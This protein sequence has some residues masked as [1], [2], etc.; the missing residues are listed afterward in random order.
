MTI[1]QSIAART[2]GV[3]V[4]LLTLGSAVYAA[5]R[6]SVP[7][8]VIQ[9]AQAPDNK[10]GELQPRYQPVPPEE[11]SWYNDSYLFAATRGVAHST[12]QPVAKVA[13]YPLTVVFDVVLLPFAAIGGLFG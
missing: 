9:I 5:P 7:A 12:M 10:S 2:L 13:L 8:N 4:L 6:Q 1:H 11:K 3:A